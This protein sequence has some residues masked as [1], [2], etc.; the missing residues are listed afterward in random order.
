MSKCCASG[1]GWSGIS[2]STTMSKPRPFALWI[3]I[4]C[5]A[6]TPG[7]WE[8]SSRAI[9]SAA[10]A[11]ETP[12]RASSAASAPNRS[13]ARLRPKSDHCGHKP[14]MASP[15]VRAKPS[16]EIKPRQSLPDVAPRFAVTGAQFRRE[17]R[18]FDHLAGEGVGRVRQPLEE[19]GD[20]DAHRVVHRRQAA[21]FLDDV[22]SVR[23]QFVGHTSHLVIAAQQ[24]AAGHR[25]L[26]HPVFG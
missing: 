7:F 16:R 5:T 19:V 25:A 22:E 4:T 17:R 15:I 10:S 24:H 3:V 9:Q 18:H 26:P 21:A 11:G 12:P 20:H 14:A 1:R 13:P 6:A 23:A 8:T 2:G